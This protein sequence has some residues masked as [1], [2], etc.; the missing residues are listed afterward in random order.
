MGACR[1]RPP[2][3]PATPVFRADPALKEVVRSQPARMNVGQTG[4][5]L[6]SREHKAG[7]RLPRRHVETLCFAKT[8]PG[9]VRRPYRHKVLSR[10]PFYKRL[11]WCRSSVAGEG[12]AGE[13]H[14]PL[15]RADPGPG[16]NKRRGGS[17]SDVLSGSDAWRVA[18]LVSVVN[19][20]NTGQSDNLGRGCR[21]GLDFARFRG[22]LFQGRVAAI[23]VV[24]PDIVVQEPAQVCF[25][26]DDRMVQRLPADAGYPTLCDAVLPG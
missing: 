5:S 26:E 16:P 9:L 22:V 25:V 19:S 14:V 21:R 11:R 7:G 2:N 18:P 10:T 17:R 4:S 13:L 1:Y 15:L 12:S 23:L 3:S 6:A 24:V 8:D 20:T